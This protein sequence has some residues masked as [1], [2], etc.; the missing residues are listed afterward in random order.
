[1]SVGEYQARLDIVLGAHVPRRIHIQS[2]I[3][4]GV[5]KQKYHTLD[6]TY[7][8]ICIL[9]H[10]MVDILKILQQFYVNPRDSRLQA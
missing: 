1:M 10:S 5:Q 4:S 6:E 9:R 3:E 8:E 2:C 7:F